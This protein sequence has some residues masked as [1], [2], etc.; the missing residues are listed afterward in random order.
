MPCWMPQCVGNGCGPLL[1]A[2]SPLDAAAINAARIAI[3]GQMTTANFLLSLAYPNVQNKQETL[4]SDI[5]TAILSGEVDAG[6]IIHENRFTYAAKG[7]VQSLDL[8][9]TGKPPPACPFPWAASSFTGICR[10]KYNCG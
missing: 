5:E 2:K 10:K 8:A 3:P 4:F 7:L 1:I 6:V 9:N